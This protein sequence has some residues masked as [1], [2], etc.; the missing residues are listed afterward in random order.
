MIRVAPLGVDDFCDE[1][2]AIPYLFFQLQLPASDSSRI[3]EIIHQP[4]HMTTL[5]RDD[6]KRSFDRGVSPNPL[7]QQRRGGSNRR[8]R[9]AEF[10]SQ[11]CQKLVLAT[12]GR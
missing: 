5:A 1:R 7:L 11:G 9:V 10:M 4:G 3:Q 2:S 12:V 8:E 6:V